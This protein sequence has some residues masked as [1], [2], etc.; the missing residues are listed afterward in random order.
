[1]ATLDPTYYPLNSATESEDWRALVQENAVG[2]QQVRARRTKPKWAC[3]YPYSRQQS[4][5]I[6]SVQSFLRSLEGPKTSFYFW[7]PIPWHYWSSLSAGSGTGSKVNFEFPGRDYTIGSAAVTVAG[8]AKTEGTHY[9]VGTCNEIVYSED[10]SQTGSWVA[11]AGSPTITRT[12]SQTDPLG[13]S[14]AWRI[15][16]SGGSGTMKL[17]QL[18]ESTP[19]AGKVVYQEI[20]IKNLSSTKAVT[21]SITGLSTQTIAASQDWT[22]VQLY[23]TATGAANAAIWFSAPATGD[24]LDFRV[25]HPWAAL[26]QTNH[27]DPSPLWGYVPTGSAAIAPETTYGKQ[28]VVFYSGSIPTAGQAVVISCRCRRLLSGRAS[29]DTAWTTPGFGRIALTLNLIGE[30]V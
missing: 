8:S 24:S 11:G 15:E 17:Y 26:T 18:Y 29:N 30:E 19:A 22:Q 10:L 1:M 16:T 13:G 14:T 23:W 27:G 12:G 6:D 4:A 21:V 7:T 3:S 28:Q 2:I 5:A 9:Q 25:W 20:W